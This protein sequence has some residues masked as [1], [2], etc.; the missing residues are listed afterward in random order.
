MR[1]KLKVTPSDL[2]DNGKPRVIGFNK[3][4]PYSN[5]N[6]TRAIGGRKS[7]ARFMTPY[8]FPVV[9]KVSHLAY[10]RADIATN[11]GVSTFGEAFNVLCSGGPN[12]YSQFDIMLNYLWFNKN[13][14]YSW[15]IAD[16]ESGH[17]GVFGWSSL[18]K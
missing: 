8:A 13:D 7:V 14:E 12:S 11:M 2:F 4:S 17:F 3:Q 6:T 15:H 16:Y 5:A 1:H 10:M 9:L 18:P